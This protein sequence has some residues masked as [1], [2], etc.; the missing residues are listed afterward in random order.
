MCTGHGYPLRGS[1]LSSSRRKVHARLLKKLSTAEFGLN[2]R[3][4]NE[5]WTIS[6]DEQ[7]CDFTKP[8]GRLY[9]RG[10]GCYRGLN[11]VTR[12]IAF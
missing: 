5:L 1:G 6:R 7:A 9:F 10:V 8:V 3:L 11:S 2:L 12:K 4:R